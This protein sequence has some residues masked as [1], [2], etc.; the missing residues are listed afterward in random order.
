MFVQTE[1][2]GNNTILQFNFQMKRFNL[3]KHLHQFAELVY[4]IDGEL[5]VM[6]NNTV[7]TLH[8]DDYIFIMPLQIHAFSTPVGSNSV[9]S[10]FSLEYFPEIKNKSGFFRGTGEKTGC[11]EM[12]KYAF[13]EGGLGAVKFSEAEPEESPDAR[14][15]LALNYSDLTNLEYLIRFK[16]AIYSL[17]SGCD[18]ME[19]GQKNGSDAVE[20][21]LLW[22]NEHFT[23]PIT[24]GDAAA[25]LNYSRNYLS[26]RIKKVLGMSFSDV[27][28]TFRIV[29]A[30]EL[31]ERGKTALDAALDSGFGSER[32]FYRVFQKSTGMTP[33]EYAVAHRQIVPVQKER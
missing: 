20:R 32:N 18:T 28:S 4:C 2:F 5:I 9:V 24:L 15:A 31:L 1:N 29:K 12:F 30:K 7:I 10:A 17:F 33:R 23:D 25:A 16:A 13:L 3:G 11:S 8:R 19:D 6:V 21:L 26:H 27:I 14:N 22:L